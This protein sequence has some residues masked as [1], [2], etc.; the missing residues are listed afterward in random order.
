MY[1]KA[2]SFL[3][4]IYFYVILSILI[5]VYFP[6]RRP[7]LPDLK[8]SYRATKGQRLVWKWRNWPRGQPEGHHTDGRP[9]FIRT[10]RIMYR[11][12]TNLRTCIIPHPTWTTSTNQ[13]TVLFSTN[14]SS[15][16]CTIFRNFHQRSMP[17]TRGRVWIK[18][19]GHIDLQGQTWVVCIQT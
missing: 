5:L 16:M 18:V 13:L 15:A 3:W 7:R 8:L 4:E 10:T 14:Q 19:Q 9:L 6:F 1:L 17:R 12:L 11:P 2:L